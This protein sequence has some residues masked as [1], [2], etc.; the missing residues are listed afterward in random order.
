[1][2]SIPYINS[3]SPRDR[4]AGR[5]GHHTGHRLQPGLV[6]G[7]RRLR[8]RPPPENPQDVMVAFTAIYAA[9]VKLL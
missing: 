4:G 6:R 8:G 5:F 2:K 9:I 1:L 3:L 7:R